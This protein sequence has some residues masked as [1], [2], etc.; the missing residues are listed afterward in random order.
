M[1]QP[2]ATQLLQELQQALQHTSV[3]LPK[4]ELHRLSKKVVQRL[5][6]VSREEFDT[7][8]AVLQRTR[9]KVDA[10]EQALSQLQ[11]ELDKRSS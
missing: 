3:E 2:F 1:F 11:Q 6:L 9:E 8:S 7:Q 5:D 4:E 10:L